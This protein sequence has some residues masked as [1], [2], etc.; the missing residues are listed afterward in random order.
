MCIRTSVEVVRPVGQSYGFSSEG[1]RQSEFFPLLMDSCANR[2][3]PHMCVEVVV[4]GMLLGDR[5]PV[6][7]LI[8]LPDFHKCLG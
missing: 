3:P 8:E 2:A 5:G 6:E 7:R 4:S 1:L